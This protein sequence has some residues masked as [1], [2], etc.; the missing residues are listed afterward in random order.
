MQAGANA[1]ACFSK[2]PVYFLA[3]LGYNISKKEVI[4]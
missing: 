4:T 2:I 1:S 3:N